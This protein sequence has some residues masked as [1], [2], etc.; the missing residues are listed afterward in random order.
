M[1]ASALFDVMHSPRTKRAVSWGLLMLAAAFI[2]I[3]PAF[4]TMP[5]DSA[6]TKIASSLC[7]P[8]ARAVAVVALVAAGIAIGF[9]EAKGWLHHLLV[10]LIGVSIAVLAPRIL[11]LFIT[12]FNFQCA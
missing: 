2:F 7:G 10:V 12:G 9:G 3:E 1:S 11:G 5:W 4:A 8:T 6:I